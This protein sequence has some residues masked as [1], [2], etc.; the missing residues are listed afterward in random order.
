MDKYYDKVKQMS[1]Q[2]L[3]EEF[4]VA[5]MP[6]DYDG[7]FTKQGLKE[8]EIVKAELESRLLKIR[9]LS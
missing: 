8:L 6:D 7:A 9:F 2:E 3:W 4:Q 1:N 5:S